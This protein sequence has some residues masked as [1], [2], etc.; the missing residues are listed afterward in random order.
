MRRAAL[1]QGMNQEPR[2]RGKR[3]ERCSRVL[4]ITFRILGAP[5]IWIVGR[6]EGTDLTSF[7]V[8]FGGPLRSVKLIRHAK[9]TDAAYAC[10]ALLKSEKAA[11]GGSETTIGECVKRRRNRHERRH[12]LR[13]KAHLQPPS[14]W[15]LH[16][17]HTPLQIRY[18]DDT[19]RAL[20]RQTSE[21]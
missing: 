18:S 13:H 9:S 11:T 14:A 2:K 3:R 20:Q 7:A 5:R 1:V 17:V 8:A 15:L 19:S 12:N 21:R 16:E 10:S 4:H 6:R